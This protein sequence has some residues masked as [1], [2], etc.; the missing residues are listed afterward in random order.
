MLTRYHISDSHTLA[1]SVLWF[2]IRS[3][4]LAP[5]FP[6]RTLTCPST[7][8]IP[9]QERP[10]HDCSRILSTPAVPRQRGGGANGDRLAVGIRG[11]VAGDQ[12][13]LARQ[14]LPARHL[15]QTL[16]LA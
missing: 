7:S 11:G 8:P 16:L 13:F 3:G 6:C 14:R 5:S 2:S 12:H 9:V 10:G 15:P 4:S 1:P